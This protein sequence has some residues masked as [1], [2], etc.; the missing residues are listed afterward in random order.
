MAKGEVILAAGALASP[1]ILQLSGIGPAGILT[2]AGVPVLLDSPGVGQN[3]H[4]HFL[5]GLNFRLRDWR[6]GSDNRAFTGSALL[7]NVARHLLLGTGPLS[8]G[9]SEAAA[10]VRVLPESERPDT[11]VMYQ[12]YSLDRAAA[13]MAFEPEPGMSVYSFRLRPESRGSITI[14]SGDP[15]APPVI[16]PRYLSVDS[17][18]RAAVE[19]VRFTRR[20]MAQ[21]ALAPF[22]V[23]ETAFS[24]G[25]QS[26]DD[27]LA[28]YADW[29]SAGFHATG[30]VRMGQDN[31]APLDGRL[32]LRGID[33][34]RVVDISVFP[35]MIAGNT[36]APAMALG[37]RAAQL[38]RQD[39]D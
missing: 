38:I 23:G 15:S 33:G 20:L 7:R 8:Y 10:F 13:G 14:A 17:D 27:I 34:L 37:V 2:A 35:E 24:A 32:R 16:D 1:R 19:A 39:N 3:M 6:S 26:D 29:A 12:P 30:T 5:L 31:S 18:R 4:E 11:Q 21:P 36:N 22:V 28:M 25:A 9:S